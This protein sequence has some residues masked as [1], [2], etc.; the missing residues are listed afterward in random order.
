MYLD[1]NKSGTLVLGGPSM[2]DYQAKTLDEKIELDDKIQKLRRFTESVLFF[3]LSL[4]ESS[5]LNRQLQ[6]MEQY[7]DILTKRIEVWC[8]DE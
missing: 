2:K 7:S 5:L 8:R 1:G 4:E 6:T 3:D